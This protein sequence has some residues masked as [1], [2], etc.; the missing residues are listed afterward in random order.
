VSRFIATQCTRTGAADKRGNRIAEIALTPNPR[1]CSNLTF[2]INSGPWQTI[3]S[4]TNAGLTNLTL[5]YTDP[6]AASATQRFY[7]VGLVNP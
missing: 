6:F 2:W 5:F 3:A 7:R 1:G 4:Q